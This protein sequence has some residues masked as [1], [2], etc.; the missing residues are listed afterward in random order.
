MAIYPCYINWKLKLQLKYAVSLL[1]DSAHKGKT[2]VEAE[3]NICSYEADQYGE[4]DQWTYSHTERRRG[5]FIALKEKKLQYLIGRG[6]EKKEK[7]LFS[8]PKEVFSVYS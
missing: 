8:A 7:Q 6:N 1:A 4:V 3:G 2:S 5:S